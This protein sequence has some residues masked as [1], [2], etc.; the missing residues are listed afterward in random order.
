MKQGQ[1]SSSGMGATK[2]EPRPRAVCPEAV[3]NIGLQQITYKKIPM[4]EGRGLKAPM[5]G[6]EV[7]HCGSQGR[8]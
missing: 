7:H 2:V 4:Y 1:A 5:A 8:H 3:A 6:E